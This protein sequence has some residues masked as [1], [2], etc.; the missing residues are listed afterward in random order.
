MDALS[1][2]ANVGGYKAVLIAANAYGRYFPLLTT[3]AGHGQAGQRAD[4]RHRRRG[5]PGDRHGS[6]TRCGRQGLRRPV[7]D[8]GAGR[9]ARGD[10][11]RPEVGRRRVRRG[12]LRAP[13]DARGAGRAAGRAQRPH[14]V[15][16]RRDHDR[17]GPRAPA[18]GARH[19]GGRGRD[20]AR[21]RHRRHGGL[22]ARRQRR[23][24]EGR[25]DD[26][27]RQRRHDP[28]PGQP[29]GDDA[30]RRLG[31]STR[32]TSRRCS[33]TSSRTARWSSTSS[34]EITAATVITHDGQ[35]VQAAT[36]KLLEPAAPTAAGGAA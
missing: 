24:V 9:V 26:R 5:A 15:D 14:R 35:V 20:E 8:E 27:D 34:E 1:S 18:A 22:S 19:G 25:R 16:G 33:S 11:H 7:R 32:A 12:R 23:A 2:Q 6:A 36:K 10:V 3:A 17:P 30:G 13:A 4:P 31:R 21:L 29:A 28:R